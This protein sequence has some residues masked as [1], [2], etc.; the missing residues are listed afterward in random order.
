MAY[1]DQQW[2]IKIYNNLAKP[3]IYQ[4]VW[5][6]AEFL[7]LEDNPAYNVFDV[8]GIDLV[9]QRSHNVNFMGQR[10]R[11][12]ESSI[13]KGYDDFTLRHERPGTGYKSESYKLRR[14][15]RN[16]DNIAKYYAYGHVNKE[17][18]G[19][20]KFRI[21]LLKKFMEAWENNELPEPSVKP[22]SNGSSNFLPWRFKDLPKKCIFWELRTPTTLDHKQGRLGY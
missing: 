12:V 21:L 4:N 18:T 9:I 1:R 19:F 5:P 16:G 14:A 20:A 15:Y 3:L 2:A 13:D 6:D 22:N 17:R 11:T 8:S 7:L 10:F